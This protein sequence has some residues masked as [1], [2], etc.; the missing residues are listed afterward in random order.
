MTK[1]LKM[2]FI[3]CGGIARAHWRGI[4]RHVPEII[5]TACIDENA[6]AARAFSRLTGAQAFQSLDEALGSGDFDAVDIML[7][8]DLH[9]TTAL[10]C[11]AADKHV[12]LEKPL[13]HTL[14]SALRI[15]DAAEAQDKVFMI[16]EQAHYWPDVHKAAELIQAGA[17]GE[18]LTARAFFFDP[19]PAESSASKPWRY[20]I[21]R[22]GGGISIDGGAHWIRPMRLMLGEITDVLAV[23]QSQIEEME[24]ESLAHAIFRFNSGLI[25]TFQAL[26]KGGATGPIEDFRITGTEG[27]III[28]RGRA[29]RLMLYN[30][31]APQGSVIMEEVYTGKV[32]S[33]GAELKDF[34]QAVLAGTQLAATP[35]YALGELRTA[36]AMYESTRTGGWA[37][38]WS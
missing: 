27:E 33:F 31:D 17:I 37:S 10:A 6:D 2:A 22:A 14:D 7:P 13:A 3:G 11:F 29:G 4:E 16:A 21:D 15:L 30:A 28:E 5:V 20:F 19:L 8:H 36:R 24:G 35:R 26:M 1:Q 25:G 23:T 12:C 32:D 9:E 18:V 34:S 38:V